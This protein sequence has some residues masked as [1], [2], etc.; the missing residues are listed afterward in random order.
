[1]VDVLILILC[2]AS[3]FDLLRID[4]AGKRMDVK[5]EEKEGVFEPATQQL[6]QQAKIGDSYIFK[7]VSYNCTNQSIR[8][9]AYAIQ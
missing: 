3:R 8:D 1:M 6:I 2:G 7:N 5:N 9:V 4:T